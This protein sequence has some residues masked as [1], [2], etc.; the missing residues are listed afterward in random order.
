M[1]IADNV[2]F[3]MDDFRKMVFIYNALL[4]GWSVQ[5][6]RDSNKFMFKKN[7]SEIQ[8]IDFEVSDFINSNLDVESL[9][10][11]LR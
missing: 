11:N 4:A 1:N 10:R 3:T 7:R 6:V 9:L 2:N 8:E 5:K